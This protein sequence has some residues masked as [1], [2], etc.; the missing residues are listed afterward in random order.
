MCPTNHYMTLGKPLPSLGDV[1]PGNEGPMSP[2]G[3]WSPSRPRHP[4]MSLLSSTHAVGM[5]GLTTA[6]P[7]LKQGD[8]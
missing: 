8:E 3:L 7:V 6:R 5:L 1:F 4:R 2:G